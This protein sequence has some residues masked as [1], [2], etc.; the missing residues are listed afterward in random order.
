MVVCRSR[1]MASIASSPRSRS[2][3]AE[4]A[5]S[6][7]TRARS[8]RRVHGLLDAA[9]QWLEQGERGQGR[10]GDGERGCLRH[11]RQHGLEPE[12]ATG[13]H[14]D[15]DGRDHRP[16]HRPADDAVDR[17]Q[18]VAE[19]G[20]RH[21]DRDPGQR[22][23]EQDRSVADQVGVE[24]RARVD[25]AEQDDRRAAATSAAGARRSIPRRKR[26][27][28]A[29]ALAIVITTSPTSHSTP[30]DASNMS[31]GRK[32]IG[33]A[34][35]QTFSSSTSTP[36]SCTKAVKPRKIATIA[37]LEGHGQAPAP[38]QEPAVRERE[39]QVQDRE[40]QQDPGPAQRPQDQPQHWGDLRWRRHRAQ[41]V[42]G[43]HAGRQ[44]QAGDHQQPA[45]D[46]PRL[47]RHDQRAGNDEGEEAPDQGQGSERLDGGRSGGLTPV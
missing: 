5:W 30:S 37:S 34:T 11:P 21:G 43:Q 44:G 26:S 7:S 22:E 35:V 8:N 27:T 41:P 31:F 17:V 24:R 15:Q 10:G 45:D 6:P 42:R 14:G 12:H 23:P 29:A 3:N 33:F 38:R 19:H 40:D 28:T 46:V 18:P 16:R 32:P 36:R 4:A 1:A 13:E 25:R 20:D 2:A 9:A 39:E 47:A